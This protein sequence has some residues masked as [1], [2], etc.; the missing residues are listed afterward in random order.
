MSK[1]ITVTLNPAIDKTTSTDRIVPEKKLR[2]I[3]PTYEPGGG[4][5]NVSRALAHLGS[6]SLAMYFSGG[7]NGNFFKKLL[8]EEQIQSLVVPVKTHIRTNIIV[9]EQSTGS[10]FRFGME[11]HPV[12]E[13]DW[14]L[15]LKKLSHISGYEYVIA[16]GSLPD[17]VPSDFFGRM[18]A[19]VKKSNARLIVDTSGEALQQ[20]VKEGVFMIKPNLGE[21]SSLYGKEELKQEEAVDAARTIIADKGCEVMV[22]SMGKNGGI[23]VTEK[24]A[25]HIIPP[26][27]NVKSTVGAGDSMVAGI[28]FALTHGM[29]W[30]EVLMYGTACGTAATINNGTALCHLKDVLEIFEILKSRGT[31]SI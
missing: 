24:E 18:A 2:C 31:V 3:S 14:K 4:G 5:I 23:L 22:I 21:L 7:F 11:S 10:Q 29:S 28:V 26:E 1:I 15:F 16:S 9:V 8:D 12:Q 25:Y 20:A 30:N 19:I 17:G 13:K 27:T 6:D